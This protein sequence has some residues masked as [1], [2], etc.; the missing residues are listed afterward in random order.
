MDLIIRNGM[1]IDGTGTPAV[2]VDVG[3]EGGKIVAVRNLKHAHGQTEL[4]AR[5]QAVA[6]GFIDMHTHCDFTIFERPQADS[7]LLQGAMDPRHLDEVKQFTGM[8][9]ADL[10]WQW[11]SFEEYLAALERAR[12]GLN[13]VPLVGLG[14]VRIAVM[15]FARRPLYRKRSRGCKTWWSLQ[16]VKGR[17]G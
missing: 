6:P 11:Q 15:G 2:Q 10:P 1:V 9:D 13:I 8:F 3:A 16:C 4:D 7:Y 5:G 12:P 14:A 17:P